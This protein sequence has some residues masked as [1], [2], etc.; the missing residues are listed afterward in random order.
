METNPFQKSLF[1][2]SVAGL[3]LY[4]NSLEIFFIGSSSQGTQLICELFPRLKWLRLNNSC[5]TAGCL[6]RHKHQ[7]TSLQVAGY[8][9]K[10]I[11][12]LTVRVGPCIYLRRC[13]SSFTVW[14]FWWTSTNIRSYNVQPRLVWFSAWLVSHS[15]FHTMRTSCVKWCV[16]TSF[17]C[18][19]DFQW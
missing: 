2:V 17:F 1:Q 4:M 6:F 13:Q 3:S 11:F 16:K 5:L 12:I 7:E 19:W 8:G 10:H 14:F 15:S 18:R 9:L